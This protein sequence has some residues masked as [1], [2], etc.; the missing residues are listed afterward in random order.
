MAYVLTLIASVKKKLM[1]IAAVAIDVDGAYGT[2]TVNNKT[3]DASR[4][5]REP[6]ALH[7]PSRREAVGGPPSRDP[8]ECREDRRDPR[9]AKIGLRFGQAALADQVGGCPIRP[10]AVKSHREQDAAGERPEF[11]ITEDR[12]W[13][14]GR[15]LLRGWGRGASRRAATSRSRAESTASRG[16]RRSRRCSAIRS[17]A[18]PI[19]R[20][21]SRPHCRR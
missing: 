16:V 6:R 18:P 19:R 9:E 17:A 15:R 2:A 5:T 13:S 10:Q 20:A 11:R 4:H 1:P 7:A 21:E 3:T 12:P 8:A 14:A